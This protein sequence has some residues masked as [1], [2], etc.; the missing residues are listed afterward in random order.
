MKSAYAWSL[1][2]LAGSVFAEPVEVR[3]LDQTGSGYTFKRGNSCLLVTARHVVPDVA[4]DITVLDRSGAKSAAQRIYDNEAYDLAVV[5]LPDKSPVACTDSWPDSAW[6]KS[7]RFTSKS[8]FEVHRDYPNGRQVVVL[9]RHAGGSNNTV[10]LAYTDKTRI[11]ESD[12]GS[13]V[14][15]DD[16][17]AGI[18]QS[19]DTGADR[20]EVLRF[21]VIDQL[22]GARFRGDT[23]KAPLSLAG[24]FRSNRA[25]PQLTTFV[26]SWLLEKAGR[27]LV[28]MGNAAAQ[29]EV[30]VEI[31]SWDRVSVDNPKYAEVQSQLSMCGKKGWLWEQMC[32][33]G[34]QQRATTPAKMQAHQVMLNVT[35]TERDGVAQ[36]KLA[37]STITPQ[38]S[39]KSAAQ[40]QLEVMQ[41][42]FASVANDM[43]KAGTCP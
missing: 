28:S 13:I 23:G 18:V 1:C 12:S 33:S 9:L 4:A 27:S 31:V 5:A 22:V 20:V 8:E 30:R 42:S 21:D 14:R 40:Q 41:L 24:V 37:T 17:L 25:D 38:A 32:K 36:S 35:M 3:Q 2:L 10:T 11:K 19:V 16:K 26:Q 29:C 7:T 6:M 15:S 43:F 39:N 34:Q